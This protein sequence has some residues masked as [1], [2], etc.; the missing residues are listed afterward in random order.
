ML[1]LFCAVPAFV[2]TLLDKWVYESAVC[3]YRFDKAKAFGIINVVAR[4]NKMLPIIIDLSKSFWHRN[5]H[6]KTGLFSLLR[7]SPINVKM[8]LGF[9]FLFIISFNIKISQISLD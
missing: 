2:L 1:G 8:L 4:E 6:S 7:R 3:T 5:I 9:F